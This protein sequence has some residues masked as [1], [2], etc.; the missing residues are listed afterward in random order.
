[1]NH[2]LHCAIAPH[3]KT[4][5]DLHQRTSG[6]SLSEILEQALS[7]YLEVGEETLF[8]TSTINAL[9]EGV[10]RGDLTVAELKEHGDFGLGTFND[11]DG[12]MVVLDGQ[13]YQLR[14]DGTAHV[15]EDGIKT[16]FATVT[17]W[18]QD[19][20]AK[21]QDPLTY[22]QLQNHLSR[23]LPSENMFYA[24][25]IEGTFKQIKTRTVSRQTEP[26][27]LIDAAAQ[28]TIY[29]F[30]NIGG[31]LVGFWV[32]LYMQTVNVPGFHLHFLS[33]DLSVGGHLLDCLTDDITIALDETPFTQIALPDT[34]AFRSVDLTKDTRHE[35]EA[36]EQDR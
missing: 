22:D 10:Y 14:S 5:L 17:V 31:T 21:S 15:V 1:M 19:I 23:L 11:L 16:P 3:L 24:I 34:S 25:R 33:K 12:E 13:V 29:T 35:L 8:Q 20:F 9:V 7:Q 36:A 2:I 27:R 30:N 26:T 18:N 32:P 4:A 28:A 6:L